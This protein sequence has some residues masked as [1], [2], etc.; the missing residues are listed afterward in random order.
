VTDA[1]DGERDTFAFGSRRAAIVAAWNVLDLVT[2]PL[3]QQQTERRR[4]VVS[5]FV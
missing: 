3:Q 1:R 4:V 2:M 5:S